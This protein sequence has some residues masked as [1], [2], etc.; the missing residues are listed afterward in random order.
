MNWAIGVDIYTLLC[1]YS[2]LLKGYLFNG[3]ES[4]LVSWMNLETVI[5]NEVNQKEKNKYINTYIGNL[6]KMVLMNL[7]AGRNGDTDGLH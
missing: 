6:K 4:V 1:I 3:F 7:L 5:Q 2:L